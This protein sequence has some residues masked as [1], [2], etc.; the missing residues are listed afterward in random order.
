MIFLRI[1]TIED[2]VVESNSCS[3]LTAI[4]WCMAGDKAIKMRVLELLGFHKSANVTGSFIF[5][6]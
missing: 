4:D 3:L 6:N 1:F 5:Y 2:N